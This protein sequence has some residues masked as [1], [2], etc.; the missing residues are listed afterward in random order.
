MRWLIDGYNV[1][2]RDADL[3]AAESGGLEAGR[4]ALLRKV[5]GAAVRMSDRFTVVFDGA[6]VR[7]S[8]AVP[9]RLEVIF[10]RPP[11]KADDVLV[12]L[13]REEGAGSVVVT[14]DRAVADAARRARCTVVGAGDFLDALDAPGVDDGADAEDADEERETSRAGNPHRASRDER[15]ARRV[16]ERLR[17]AMRRSP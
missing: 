3:R 15:A 10:S 11:Q 17:A 6:P 2:R 16:L 13:A 14:S 8:A 1:I 5:A 4:A 9:G 12:R 7:G